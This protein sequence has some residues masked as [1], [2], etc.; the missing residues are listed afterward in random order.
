[1]FEIN[2]NKC[3]LGAWNKNEKAER[4]MG[5]V[6]WRALVGLGAVTRPRISDFGTV[7]MFHML[8]I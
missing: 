4:L 1:M 6:T 5:L 7:L 8:T 2:T 3:V